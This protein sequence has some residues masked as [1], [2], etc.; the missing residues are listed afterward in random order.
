MQ[1]TLVISAALAMSAGSAAAGAPAFFPPET[2][3]HPV[4]DVLHGT[5]LTDRYRWLE[6]GKDAGCRHGRARSMKR[7]GNSSTAAR[8]PCPA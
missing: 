6:D 1:W 7:R 4:V 5:T 3:E 8:R 2:P